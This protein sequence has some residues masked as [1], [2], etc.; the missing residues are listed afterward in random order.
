MDNGRQLQV[1]LYRH[2]VREV[3][4]LEILRNGRADRF[5]V[6]VGERRDL[7]GLPDAVDAREHMVPRLGIVGL[8][9]T[10]RIRHMRLRYE[11]RPAL[12]SHRRW[13]APSTRATVG[14]LPA[15]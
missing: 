7:S 4:T 13:P 12:S 11:S 15:M 5:P 9:L 10:D 14:L 6:T 8:N 1:N 2:V 3:V